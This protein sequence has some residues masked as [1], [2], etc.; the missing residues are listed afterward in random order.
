MVA[1]A[2][3]SMCNH[4]QTPSPSPD[5]RELLLSYLPGNIAIRIEPCAGPV[6]EAV[7]QSNPFHVGIS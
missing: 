1:I 4:D 6:E 2:A 5:D 3:S 7:T